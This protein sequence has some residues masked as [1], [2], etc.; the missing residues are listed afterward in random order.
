[1]FFFLSILVKSEDICP[2]EVHI[3]RNPGCCCAGLVN[4]SQYPEGCYPDFP[5]SIIPECPS[6]HWDR[7]IPLL[8][9]LSEELFCI[10]MA[11]EIS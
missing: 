7:S 1:M 8:Q 11:H 5:S 3:G 4:R 9:F 2:C 6:T 10:S